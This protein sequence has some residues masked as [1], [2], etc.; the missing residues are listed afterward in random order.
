MIGRRGQRV[1]LRDVLADVDVE[2]WSG[3]P[4]VE[5]SALVHDSRDAGPGAC[6]ACIP[7]TV[8][9]GHDH[10]PAAVTAGAVALLVE[11]M[12]ELP[13][14]QARVRRVRS[15]LGPAAAR[16]HDYPSR[17]LRCL[18]VT[19]TNGKTTTTYLLE[20]IARAAGERP[21]VIRTVGARIDGVEVP[22]ERTTPEATELQA[23]LA[24]MR[25]TGVGSV[26]LEV[27]SHALDQHRVD[28]IW[29]RAVCFTNLS[30]EHLDY[31]GTMA[32]YFEAKAR[33]F[34]PARTAAAAVNI[35]DLHGVQLLAR[36]REAG[37]PVLAFSATAHDDADLIAERVEST[38]GG[39]RFDLVDRR[40][41]PDR[42]VPVRSPLVGRFNLANALAAAATALVGGLPID[43]V[44]AGLETAVIVPGRLERVDDGRSF[45]V[46]VD[47]AH[48]P[49]ALARVLEVG[50]QLTATGRVIVVF[51]C[52][53]TRDHAKRPLMGRVAGKGA[54]LTVVTSDNPRSEDPATIAAAIVDGLREEHGEFVLE[55]DR[56]AAVRIAVSQ[57]RPG[58]V[59][60]V[61]GR[62]HEPGQTIGSV[63]RPF[64]D[65]VVA[66]EELE[67]LRCA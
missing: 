61:A 35:D 8:S 5:V 49:D 59:V 24:R 54:D 15:V 31:H 1:R 14:S 11:R 39:N 17:T 33:L 57:A 53:G 65:R 27:S 23:L 22:E 52:G 56:R 40:V 32:A 10:A 45:T 47:Y 62:G 64:D 20:A 67:A 16:F 63:T 19:G 29:F 21:G 44:V 55:L 28:G 3:D 12:L 25:D 9:D 66:R 41:E 51:G 30:H 34:E 7:G 37:L 42:R 46:L 26:A 13:V 18:G 38:A 48:T 4:H 2:E 36:A 50:R 43:A 58:D 6:F 60:I